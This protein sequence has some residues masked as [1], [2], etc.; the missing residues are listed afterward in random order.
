MANPHLKNAAL[1]V[2]RSGDSRT[3]V[4]FAE[5]VDP[6]A[7]FERL[8]GRPAVSAPRTLAISADTDDGGEM[9]VGRVSEPCLIT[10]A[11]QPGELED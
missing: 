10:I 3:G 1:I 6:L 5:A 2:L 8:F 7:D 4:W 9:A 11:A